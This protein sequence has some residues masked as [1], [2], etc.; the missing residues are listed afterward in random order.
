M[1]SG[2]AITISASDVTL[3][4]NRHVLDN[5]GATPPMGALGISAHRQKNVVVKNGAL[6]GFYIAVALND[7]SP[8]TI[9]Q[10]NVVDSIVAEARPELSE[11]AV[12]DFGRMICLRNHEISTATVLHDFDE[13]YRRRAKLRRKAAERS[14]GG[15]VRRLR[16]DKGLRQKDF[17]GLTAKEIARIERGEVKKPH[18]RTLS[19]IARCL[20]VS[21]Q[22]IS[23]Y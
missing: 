16:L 4:M 6:R 14:L 13:Q 17:P 9:S 2:A 3:D 19:K 5:S 10:G 20:G 21:T 12:A 23:T 18:E 15:T 8:F 22:D 1:I 11:I 7:V